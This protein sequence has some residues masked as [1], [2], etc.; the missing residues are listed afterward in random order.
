MPISEIVGP[1][2]AGKTVLLLSLSQRND[3]IQVISGLRS[4]KNI[5]FY[6][7]SALRLLP[8]LIHQC[9]VGRRFT[10]Q[11]INMMIRLKALLPILVRQAF[12]N[13]TVII[14]QGPLYTL[15]WLLEYDSEFTLSHSIERWWNSILKQWASTLD[16]VIW[17]DAPD[18]ILVERIRARNRWHRVKEKSDKEAKEFLASYRRSYEQVFS[19]LM[20][21][22][23][24]KVFRFD[25]NQHSLDQLTDK[26]LN[27]IDIQN[28]QY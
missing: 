2:G 28:E 8:F 7:R 21:N 27:A 6:M 16:V 23:G 5:L 15:T 25:A 11:V 14:D 12:K 22:G 9:R 19:K 17:L 20:A 1:A 3:N 13:S 26:V 24:P 4:M 10:W 18:E